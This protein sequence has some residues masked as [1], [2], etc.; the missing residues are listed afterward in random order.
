MNVPY[1][2]NYKTHRSHALRSVTQS[3]GTIF[4][5]KN[6]I[7]GELKNQVDKIWEAFWTGGFSSPLI[8]IEQFTFLLFLRRMDERQ[9]L[10]EKKA[11]LIGSEVKKEIYTEAQKKFRWHCLKSLEIMHPS[12]DDTLCDPAC[13]TAGFFHIAS[14]PHFQRYCDKK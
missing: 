8:V 6:M 1:I 10:E 7:T 12:K 14:S 11:N 9:L 2:L 5:R 3:M 4:Y 13:S